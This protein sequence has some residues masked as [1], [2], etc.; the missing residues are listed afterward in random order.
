MALD[1]ISL[2]DL[3]WKDMVEAVRRRIPAA[4]D[5]KWT[6]H[7]PVDPGVT[8]LEL[9]AWLLEQRVYWMDQVP[10]PMVRA[11]LALLGERPKV[12]QCSATVLLLTPSAARPFQVIPRLSEF[13]LARSIPPMTFSSGK[14]LVLLPLRYPLGIHVGEKDRTRDL[15]RGQTLRLFPA[16]GSAAEVKIELW[17]AKPLPMP[18]PTGRFS[19]LF[20]LRTPAALSSQWVST[21]WRSVPPPAQ[22]TW[23]YSSA[24]GASPVRFGPKQVDDGTRGL[25]RSG[26]VRLEI[27]RD[28]HPEEVD[29]LGAIKYAIWLKVEKA[30]FSFPPRLVRLVPNVVIAR[31]QR[32]T[33]EHALAV[34]HWL[35]IPGNIIALNQFTSDVAKTGIPQSDLPPLEF[36]M[37]LSLLERNPLKEG[38]PRWYRWRATPDLYNHGPG[39]RVFVIDRERGEIRFGDGLT[40]RLPVLARPKKHSDGNIRLRYWV[41]GGIAGSVGEGREWDGPAGLAARNVV[42]AE[43][44]TETETVYAA[45]QRAAA[46]V[47]QLTRAI[48]ANDF[49]KLASTT[50][51]VAIRQAHAVIGYHPAHPCTP[52]PGAVT[53]LIVPDAPREEEADDWLESAFVAAPV[54]DPGILAAV[55]ARLDK[56]RLVTTEVFV[57]APHYRSVALRVSVDADPA[58]PMALEQRIRQH[59]QQFLDPLIGGDEHEGWPFGEPLRP[60][61][62]LREAQRAVGNMGKASEVAIGLDGAAPGESCREVPIQPIDL[63]WLDQVTV[64]LDRS[65]QPTGGLR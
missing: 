49:E 6:L 9:F 52:V 21:A 22:L 58:D 42:A 26:V 17:L 10:E 43:G 13:R 33:E 56:A 1:P 7:A 60:S 11:S 44:G 59:L 51:G 57:R 5:G 16:D 47:Q 61:V 19:L 20:L 4:S 29:S 14:P 2:D 53:V 25:R 37:R 48:T 35:P 40:G 3:N 8:L 36:G 15:E 28:W 62:L 23:W 30:T 46:A 39:D 55:S 45:R 64:R 12:A 27:P 54:P 24:A 34:D 38:R 65:A 41:G 32:R 50:P 31:H 18:A 63:V